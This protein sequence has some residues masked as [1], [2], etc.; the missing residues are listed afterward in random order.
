M[1]RPFPVAGIRPVDD[2]QPVL[3]HPGPGGAL[4]IETGSAAPKEPA[5]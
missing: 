3:L 2:E 1:D 4:I 5:E